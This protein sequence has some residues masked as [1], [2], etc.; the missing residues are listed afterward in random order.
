MIL[1]ALNAN[2]ITTALKVPIVVFLVLWD[3]TQ[4]LATPYV[5]SAK[6]VVKAVPTIQIVK[7]ANQDT[8]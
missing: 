2:R 5:K 8:V 4:K 6:M 3:I 7:Y 1:S